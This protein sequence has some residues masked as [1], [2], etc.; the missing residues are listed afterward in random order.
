MVD[1]RFERLEER[2]ERTETE[3]VGTNR[4]LDSVLK[5]AGTHHA[6]LEERVSRIENHLKLS[7][8]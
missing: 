8:G 4:R 3:I 1:R 6:D 7:A 2:M 5:I